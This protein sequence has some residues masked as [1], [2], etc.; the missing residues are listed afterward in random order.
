MGYKREPKYTV[1]LPRDISYPLISAPNFEPLKVSNIL[2][3][4]T[5]SSSVKNA[6]R[7]SILVPALHPLP[8][9][10]C[11]PYRIPMRSS[12]ISG[13]AS[14]L[15]SVAVAKEASTPTSRPNILFIL[16][17]DQDYH[18]T[19]LEHMPSVQKHLVEKGTA[20]ERHYCTGMA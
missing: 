7:V 16:T 11:R 8:P 18:M 20:F 3:L 5:S 19:E 10:R 17:D 4:P 2:K 12:Q 6:S 14:L 13:L 15:L 1:N 9:E